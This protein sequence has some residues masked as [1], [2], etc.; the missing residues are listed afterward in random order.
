MG[1]YT[2]WVPCVVQSQRAHIHIIIIHANGYITNGY[3]Y[4][5]VPTWVPCV[6]QSLLARALVCRHKTDPGLWLPRFALQGT[7]LVM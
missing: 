5:I 1:I 2:T 3:I 7:K 4:R 6:V